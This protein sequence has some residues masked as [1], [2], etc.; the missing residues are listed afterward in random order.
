[1]DN[2]EYIDADAVERVRDK[3]ENYRLSHY[4]SL[5][6]AGYYVLIEDWDNALTALLATAAP[7][8]SPDTAFEESKEVA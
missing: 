3:I 6:E 7:L 5:V 4:D 2:T 8:P 1:M